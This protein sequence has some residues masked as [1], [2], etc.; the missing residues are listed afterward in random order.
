MVTPIM[1]TKSKVTNRFLRICYQTTSKT[2]TKAKEG[3]NAVISKDKT[4]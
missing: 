2:T 1:H 3:I 4:K